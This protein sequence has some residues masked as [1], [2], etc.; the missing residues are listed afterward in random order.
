[1]KKLLAI[2]LF[3]TSFAT[4]SY[5]QDAPARTKQETK[6]EERKKEMAALNLSSDQKKQMKELN[7]DFKDKAHAIKDNQ[8]LSRKEKKQQI[9]ALTEERSDKMN[10]FLTPDQQSTFKETR[11]DSNK[12]KY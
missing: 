2:G 5:A 1:M 8:S 3:L 9:V 12:K 7:K 10:A 11:K 6:K 4:M